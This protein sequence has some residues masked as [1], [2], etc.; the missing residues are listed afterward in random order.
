MHL[1]ARAI[2]LFETTIHPDNDIKVTYNY[3]GILGTLP[4][5]EYEGDNVQV[6]E[7]YHQYMEGTQGIYTDNMYLGDQNQYIAFY[8]DNNGKQLKI[9]ANQIVYEITEQGEE[10]TW[11]DKIEEATQG[12]DGEDAI[13]VRIDSNI[14][15]KIFATDSTI[16]LTCHVFKG[17]TEVPTSLITQYEWIKMDKDGNEIRNGS[18]PKIAGQTIQITATD[19]FIRAI[20]GCNVTFREE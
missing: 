17:T 12:A 6:A 14:G 8:E 5:M 19:V 7:L 3:R 1:P 13:T 9:K 2:S 18:W 11:E 15:D 20:F 10:I 16:L 4:R